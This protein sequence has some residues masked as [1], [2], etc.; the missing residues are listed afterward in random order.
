[1]VVPEQKECNTR[2]G[3]VTLDAADRHNKLQQGTVA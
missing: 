3:Q 2:Y 1:M